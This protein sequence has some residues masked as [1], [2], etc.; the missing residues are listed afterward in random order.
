MENETFRRGEELHIGDQGIP[1][2][3]VF[4]ASLT[5]KDYLDKLKARLVA[6]RESL[7][8]LDEDPNTLWS[9]C[10]FV[11]TFKILSAIA[12]LVFFLIKCLS[13]CSGHFIIG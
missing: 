3:L 9:P 13:Q 8:Q 12:K 2:M 11:R 5:R 1:S 10:A 6:R 7:Q 4:E